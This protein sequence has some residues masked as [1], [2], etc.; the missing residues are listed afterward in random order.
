MQT[1]C[2]GHR[3]TIAQTP[4][5]R[6]PASGRAIGLVRAILNIGE[7]V[8]SALGHRLQQFATLDLI[9]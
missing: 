8:A 6:P 4:P 7:D 3:Q 1:N 2:A 9:F 5:P